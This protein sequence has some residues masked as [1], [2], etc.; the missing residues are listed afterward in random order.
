[1][2]LAMWHLLKLATT[3]FRCV[4]AFIR[5]RDEQAILELALRQQL[6]CRFSLFVRRTGS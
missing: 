4:P 3:L 5:S 6:A 1:M 2:L